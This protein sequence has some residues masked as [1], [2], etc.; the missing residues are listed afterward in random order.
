MHSTVITGVSTFIR[1][2]RG[3]D[4]SSS[5]CFWVGTCPWVYILLFCSLLSSP[6]V[7]GALECATSALPV[8]VPEMHTCPYLPVAGLLAYAALPLYNIVWLG[9]TAQGIF[10]HE[11]YGQALGISV[12]HIYIYTYSCIYIYICFHDLYMCTIRNAYACSRTR[13]RIDTMCCLAGSDPVLS[14]P[15]G[16]VLLILVNPP[17]AALFSAFAPSWCCDSG[18]VASLDGAASC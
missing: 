13:R 15:S 12:Q 11:D 5:L 14:L 16:Q 9:L 7:S 6:V 18:A 17:C 2:R 1:I 3:G 8:A 4:S 10:N